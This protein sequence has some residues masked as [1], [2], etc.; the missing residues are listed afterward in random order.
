MPCNEMGGRGGLF[1]EIVARDE[2]ENEEESEDDEEGK[3]PDRG[4]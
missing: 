2:C 1:P 3:C 4:Q